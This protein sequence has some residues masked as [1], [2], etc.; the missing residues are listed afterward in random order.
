[1]K[2]ACTILC[3]VILTTATAAA[4]G[5]VHSIHLILHPAAAPSPALKYPLL[6]ELRDTIPGNAVTHYRQA[7]KI[8][9]RDAPPA[10]E[11]YQIIDKWLSMPLKDFP[12]EEIGKFLQRCE[13]T[14][15]EVEAGAR[16]E[17][18]DWGLTEELRKRGIS[19]LLPDLHEMRTIATLLSLRIRYE[20]AEGRLDKAARTLQTGF[21]LSRHA[22]EEPTLISALVGIAVGSVMEGRLEEFIQQPNASNLYWSL[23]D[24]P[25]PFIDLRRPMQGERVVT[26]GTFPGMAETAADL[27][28]KPLAPEQVEKAVSQLREVVGDNNEL[29]RFQE[30]AQLAFRLAA[31]HEAA[32]KI[33]ID[34]GRPKESVD[35]MPHFQVGLLVALQQYDREF[36]ELLK[37]QSLP[38]WQSQPEI[39]K[40]SKRIKELR[41][42][43]DAPAIPVARL[44]LPRV[45]K[46]LAARVRLDRRIA[47]L[48]CVEAVRL[49]GSGHDGKLPSSLEEIKETPLPLD[50]VTGKG[51]D[52]R[53]ADDKA[54]LSCT[55]FPDLPADKNNTPSF[56]LT[57]QR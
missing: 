34:Q 33:L 29:R 57:F 12:R 27:N 47:A 31:R 25:R 44:F 13:T 17:N 2:R 1:M 45:E 24:L 7:V 50:P 39:A 36:D 9:K 6:T 51:F 55:P 46:V 11:W 35:A 16:S 26:Y 14:F 53:V 37:W 10:S 54:F 32:K 5:D 30:E 20:L 22:A 48:R 41:D 18:C 49:Y 42:D 56:E 38:Y 40:W 4:E 15:Q 21:A 23:T 8:M 43:K 52:Y 3:L 19:T 28:A